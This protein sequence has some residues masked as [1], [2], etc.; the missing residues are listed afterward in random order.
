MKNLLKKLVLLTLLVSVFAISC[1]KD[2]EGDEEKQ[3]DVTVQLTDA[4][5]PF[6][7]V[8]EAN[9]SIAKVE[10]KNSEGNYITVFEASGGTSVTYNLL[11]YSNGE[12]ANVD[13]NKLDIGTYTHAKITFAGA[14]VKMNGS[15][16]EGEGEDTI[17]SDL[18]ASTEG[19]YEY[20]ILPALV[21]EEGETSNVLIDIDVNG[22]FSFSSGGLPFGDW[23]N[24]ITQIT[25]CS[26]NPEVRVCDL[27]HTGVITG[28]VTVSGEEAENANVTITKDGKILASHTKSDGSYTFIGV[29]SGTYQVSVTVKDE[30]T[31]KKDVTVTGTETLHSNFDFL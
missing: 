22:S 13:T 12:T 4:P 2:G 5:F 24:F 29:S 17:F 15:I 30:G 20:E 14:T 7:F 19:S 26:F 1:K 16:Y 27:D 25:S 6:E 9:I 3:G 31:I 23:I 11:D 18:G 8:A 28:E 10:L 21:V